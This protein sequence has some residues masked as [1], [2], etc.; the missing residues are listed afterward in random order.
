MFVTQHNVLKKPMQGMVTR[1]RSRRQGKPI[2]SWAKDITDVFGTTTTARRVEKEAKTAAA[3]PEKD[4]L[5][6]EEDTAH[7]IVECT[8]DTSVHQGS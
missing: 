8:H 7:V 3:H 5:S 1:K 2:Q 4:M 6:E